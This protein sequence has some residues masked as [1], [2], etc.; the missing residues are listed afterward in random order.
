M[1]YKH[2]TTRPM[3]RINVA[4]RQAGISTQLLRAWERR[5]GFIS[6][7]RTD[8]GY[9]V[10]TDDDVGVLRG[11]KLLV[12]EGRSISE[13]ARL[14]RAQL[15][16]AG[17]RFAA[18]AGRPG[19]APLP[20]AKAPG[21]FLTPAIAAMVGFDAARLE[22]LLLHATG[23]G[24]LSST[25]ICDGV[26]VPLL[27]EIGER[28]EKGSLEVAAEHFGSGI[29]RRH[30]QVMLQDEARRNAGGPAVIC[31]CPEG[32]LHEGGL[33]SFALHAATR[34][35][36]PVYLGANTPPGEITATA[37]HVQAS[38]IALSVTVAS[39]RALRRTHIDRFAAWKNQR[40]GRVVW[41]GGSAALPHIDE[42]ASAGIEYREDSQGLERPRG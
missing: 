17:D 26:L 19:G 3:Y 28:W 33:L 24:A 16:Q 29:V 21:S 2:Y 18:T 41:I 4:A 7:R 1:V 27:R 39:N 37:D 10:Y 9:R 32:E 23:M 38:A 15:R 34:G 6:P 13:V 20:T 12:D 25:A 11:A 35:W 40:P 5:Y 22:S 8:A 30:L 36:L 42:L 31:A 14:P